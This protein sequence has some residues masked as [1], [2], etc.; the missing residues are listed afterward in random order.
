MWYT[1]SESDTAQTVVSGIDDFDPHWF[2]AKPVHD[3]LFVIYTTESGGALPVGNPVTFDDAVAIIRWIREGGLRDYRRAV[4]L[5][6]SVDGGPAVREVPD[7]S[8]VKTQRGR[9]YWVSSTSPVP[10]YELGPDMPLEH[11]HA[12]FNWLV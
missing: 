9:L 1:D 3:G 4:Y 6:G 10:G 12:V 7:L 5:H 2:Y 11:A 8:I